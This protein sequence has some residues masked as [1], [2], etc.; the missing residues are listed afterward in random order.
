[1]LKTAISAAID[2]CRQFPYLVLRRK[3]DES[4]YVD[5][6]CLITIVNHNRRGV[7]LGFQAPLTTHILRSEIAGPREHLDEPS[8]LGRI[9]QQVI[10]GQ[11]E[12]QEVS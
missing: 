11:G 1:M 12:H 9:V 2:R 3:P 10:E 7:A 4:I 5:G 8:P 6:P